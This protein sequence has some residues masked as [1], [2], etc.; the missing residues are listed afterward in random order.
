MLGYYQVVCH[1]RIAEFDGFPFFFFFSLNSSYIQFTPQK[2]SAW[3]KISPW[4]PRRRRVARRPSASSREKDPAAAGIRRFFSVEQRVE[5]KD[6][7]PRRSRSR[8]CPPA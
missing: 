8:R 5:K 7:G 6:I 2:L 3:R 1:D 4:R